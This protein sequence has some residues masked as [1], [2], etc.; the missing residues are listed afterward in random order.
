MTDDGLFVLPTPDYGTGVALALPCRAYEGQ[1]PYVLKG[2]NGHTIVRR[3]EPAWNDPSKLRV[4]DYADGWCAPRTIDKTAFE[5]F[6]IG[7]VIAKIDPVDP[8]A[9]GMVAL[10]DTSL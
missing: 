9:V 5:R 8:R 3:A 1:W 4:A 7:R 10:K 6:I 2:P